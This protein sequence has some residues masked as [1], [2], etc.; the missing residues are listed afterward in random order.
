M[1]VAEKVGS[2]ATWLIKTYSSNFLVLNR[3]YMLEKHVLGALDTWL[4]HILNTKLEYMFTT[5]WKR[6][7]SFPG[8]LVVM[9]IFTPLRIICWLYGSVVNDQIFAYNILMMVQLEFEF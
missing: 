4:E 6:V 2:I 5:C 9:G 3:F 1:H 7:F 8:W